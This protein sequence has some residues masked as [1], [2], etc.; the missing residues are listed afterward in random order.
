MIRVPQTAWTFSAVR[1]PSRGN[2][3]I[4]AT[5]SAPNIDAGARERDHIDCRFQTPDRNTFCTNTGSNASSGHPEK[6][7][8]DGEEDQ[9]REAAVVPHL[10]QAAPEFVLHASRRRPQGV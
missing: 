4:H 2:W 7:R 3:P 9:R 8:H 5:I 6:R 10:R 1:H